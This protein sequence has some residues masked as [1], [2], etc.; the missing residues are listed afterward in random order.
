MKKFFLLLLAFMFFKNTYAQENKP[1]TFSFSAERKNDSAFLI[2]KAKPLNGFL[3]FHINP[4]SPDDAFISQIK[5]DSASQKFISQ[6][7]KAIELTVASVI[8]DSAASLTYKGFTGDATFLISTN[9]LAKDSAEISG[10]FSWLG[11]MDDEFPSGEEKFEVRISAASNDT[12][13]NSTSEKGEA[14]LWLIFISGLIA[15]FGALLSPCI[16]AMLPVTVSFFLKRSRTRNES[17]KNAITYASSIIGIFTLLGFLFTVIFGQGALNALSSSAGF[18]II[19]FL[20]FMIFGISFLGA[21]EISL[22]SSWATKMDSK[23]GLDSFSGIF[24]MALTLVVVSF[25]CTVP[26]IGGL[27]V[28]IAKG[29]QMAPLAGFFAFSLALAIPFALLALFPGLL[30]KLAKS[31]GWLNTIKVVFGFLEIALAFKFLSS[32]DLAYHW[33]ILD[34]EVYLSIWIVVFGLMGLYL[35]GKLKFKHD[36]DLPKNDY[37]LPYLSITRLFFAIT[38]LSFV[39]YMIPGLWGAPLNGI[40]AWLPEMKTQNFNLNKTKEISNNSSSSNNIITPKKYTDILESEIPGVTVFFDYDEGMA[41]AKQMNKPA[42]IDFTGHACAN[43]RKMEREVLSNDEVIKKLQ[44]DFVLISLY[45]DDKLKLPETEWKKSADGSVL[46]QMGEQNLDFEATLTQNN[47]Q[48]Q[49]V[50]V[51][52]SGKII[53][54]AGGYNP[55]VQ[56]FLGMLN[57]AAQ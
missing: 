12:G 32:A 23:A 25:S 37:G 51:D 57:K 38:V 9:I 1:V 43:C 52:T 39:V 3:L 19:V 54:N 24:F 47:S 40:S 18:N 5:I 14:S 26:F 15:G 8:T 16:F 36:D 55:D 13:K 49:Y 41:A 7:A 10:T 30:N 33:R 53:L 48:P 28:V 46:K 11:K 42:M 2:I 35:L 6:N 17:I 44:N 31:G 56:R 21:F 34:R 29:G 27:T 20:M 22:P 50:F 4:S 45:V